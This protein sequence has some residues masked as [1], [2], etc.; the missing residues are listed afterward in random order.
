ML[1]I[2][3]LLWGPPLFPYCTPPLPPP[4]LWLVLGL[5]SA[6]EHLLAGFLPGWLWV[7][8][9]DS[10]LPLKELPGASRLEQVILPRPLIVDFVHFLLFYPS[11]SG[12]AWPLPLLPV[13]G[14]VLLRLCFVF[15]SGAWVQVG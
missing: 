15:L 3:P 6:E 2:E 4:F 14:S 7:S 1:S 9:V 11:S 5:A 10:Q 8:L 12:R 13:Q